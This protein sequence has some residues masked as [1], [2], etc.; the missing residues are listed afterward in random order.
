M[1]NGY[2]IAPDSRRFFTLWLSDGWVRVQRKRLPFGWINSSSFR[3]AYSDEMVAE[4]PQSV[5]DRLARYF[6]DM[7]LRGFNDFEE[8]DAAL[9]LA[10]S[11][12]GWV[13]DVQDDMWPPGQQV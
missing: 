7:A 2:L 12:T 1:Y 11:S 4:L 3:N 10:C 5:K 9:L 6:D 8:F 13:L